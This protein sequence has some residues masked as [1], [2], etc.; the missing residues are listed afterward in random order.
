MA[1]LTLMPLAPAVA[2]QTVPT[3]VPGIQ[4]VLAPPAEFDAV[5]ASG[6][7]LVAYAL[8]TRPDATANPVGYALWVRAMS[9]PT[10]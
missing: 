3:A 5:H 6:T 9:M 7:G 10:A 1:I 8:P 2:Q 4:A